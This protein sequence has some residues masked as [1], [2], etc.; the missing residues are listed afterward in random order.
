LKKI[1]LEMGENGDGKFDTKLL[2]K[3]RVIRPPRYESYIEKAL[4]DL[5]LD[6]N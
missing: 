1:A 2:R 4:V 5:D 3:S 6:C